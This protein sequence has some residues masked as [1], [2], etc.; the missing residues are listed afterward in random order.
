VAA[1]HAEN[2]LA[3]RYFYPGC[4]RLEP[5]RAGGWSLPRTE[6]VAARVITLPTGTSVSEDDVALI[7]SVVRVA[8]G[9]GRELRRRLAGRAPEG[10]RR[11]EPASL[12]RPGT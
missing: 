1:L 11:S 3:R 5:Y 7:C 10:A 6:G 8:A 9:S 4:H 12:S 2:I